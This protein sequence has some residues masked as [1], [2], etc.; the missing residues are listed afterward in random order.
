[1][2]LLLV[3]II[4]LVF[5]VG[6]LMCLELVFAALLLLRL[7]QESRLFCF[8]VLVFCCFNHWCGIVFSVLVFVLVLAALTIQAFLEFCDMSVRHLH[9]CAFTSLTC[10]LLLEYRQL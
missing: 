1:M 7:F 8:L 4:V 3:G 6:F 10:G 5:L 9:P 2:C